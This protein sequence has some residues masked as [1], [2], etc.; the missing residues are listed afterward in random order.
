MR[1]LNTAWSVLRSPADRAAYDEQLRGG[2][3]SRAGSAAVADAATPAR[4]SYDG[5]LV[6]P[7]TIDPRRGGAAGPRRGRWI[8]VAIVVVLVVAGLAVAAVTTSRRTARVDEPVVQ[9]NRYEIGSCVAV[10]PGADG[11]A[12]AVVSCAEPNSGRVAATTDYPRPCP[13]G[14][15]TVT[16]VAEQVSVCLTSP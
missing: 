16:V 3:G 6:D 14:T 1:E 13:G 7:R 8:P 11:P 2:P 15:E 9:T 10:G 5:H 12:V 4:P